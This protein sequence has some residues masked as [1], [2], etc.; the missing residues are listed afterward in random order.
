MNSAQR[1]GP[2]EEGSIISIRIDS[3]RG[4]CHVIRTSFIGTGPIHGETKLRIGACI[5]AQNERVIQEGWLHRIAKRSPSCQI[6]FT[7]ASW[8]T[9]LQSCPSFELRLL[10][11]LR[12][13]VR[14]V[15]LG[16]SSSR[17]SPTEQPCWSNFDNFEGSWLGFWSL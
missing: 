6:A 9:R 16:A 10:Q 15:R 7:P 8:V 14:V 4:G 11:V 17:W 3:A 5:N 13:R 2:K 1:K 12:R